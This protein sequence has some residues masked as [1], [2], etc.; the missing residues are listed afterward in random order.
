MQA[1]HC[2]YDRDVHILQRTFVLETSVRAP[3]LLL[4]RLFQPSLHV[5][6]RLSFLLTFAL[7]LGCFQIGGFY[8]LII[9]FLKAE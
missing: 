2:D 9:I 1:L 7:L 5:I 8:M 6:L 4:T 3:R